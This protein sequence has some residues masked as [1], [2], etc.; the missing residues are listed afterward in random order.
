MSVTINEKLALLLDK[1]DTIKLLVTTNE[2]GIPHAVVKNSLRLAK[3]NHL[4]YLE[5]LESS[6]TNSNMVRS[7]WFDHSITIAIVGTNGES[8]QIKGKPIKAIVNGHTFRK[9]YKELRE[10]QGDVDLAA[11]W[12]IKP[13]EILDQSFPVRRCQEETNRPYFKHLDRLAK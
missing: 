2:Q 8:Y 9:Y 12:I 4:I 11:V 3:D 13:Y 6:H 10:E 5:L 7:I 1:A